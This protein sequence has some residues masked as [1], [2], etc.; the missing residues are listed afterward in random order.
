[1][2]RRLAD[3]EDA[4]LVSDTTITTAW[5]GRFLPIHRPRS[6]LRPDGSTTM[7]FALPAAIGAKIACP[8]RSVVALSGDGGFMFTASELAT[9]VQHGIKV[10]VIVFNDEGYGWIRLMQD[11]YFGRRTQADLV[12][13]DFVKFVELFGIRGVRTS[14]PEG[15]RSVLSSALYSDSISFIEVMDELGYPSRKK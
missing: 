13:P 8:E 1:M 11:R 10:I 12:N 14:S 4:I 5:T 15:F 7:G 2:D 3:P 9:A 6:F